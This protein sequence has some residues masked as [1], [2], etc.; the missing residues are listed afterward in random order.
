MKTIYNESIGS[1]EII[2]SA[3]TEQDPETHSNVYGILVRDN[4]TKRET[5]LHSFSSTREQA[6]DFIET[7]IRNIVDPDFVMDIAE[8]YLMA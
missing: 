4:S 5:V 1:E 2:Y 8:D 3:F 6:I 7:L